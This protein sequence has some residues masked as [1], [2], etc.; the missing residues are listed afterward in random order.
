MTSLAQLM[1]PSGKRVVK[2]SG[3]FERMIPD[4]I[5]N[6]RLTG[7]PHEQCWK[8]QIQVDGPNLHQGKAFQIYPSMEKMELT[9]LDWRK[10]SRSTAYKASGNPL[11]PENGSLFL[12]L[13]E[14][15]NCRFR[16]LCCWLHLARMSVKRPHRQTL[17][18]I[19]SVWILTC[20]EYLV[21]PD[22]PGRHSLMMTSP[23]QP[24][25]LIQVSQPL[26]MLWWSIWVP[27]DCFNFCLW[28]HISHFVLRSC[29]VSLTNIQSQHGVYVTS[30]LDLY[31]YFSLDECPN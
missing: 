2:M 29:T 3:T 15:K 13:I 26:C 8:A 14:R 4:K 10:Q 22:D 1:P 12:H 21:L 28:K 31:N 27:Y 19:R 7:A 6:V 25:T 17:I 16:I 5:W 9:L 23:L 20:L 30:L 24:T 11:Q 18:P